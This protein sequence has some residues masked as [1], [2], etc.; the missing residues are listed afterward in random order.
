MK[1]KKRAAILLLAI[2]SLLMV[3]STAAADP[4]TGDEGNT[5][6]LVIIGCA[7][8]MG[9]AGVGSALGLMLAGTAAVAVTGEKP[10]LFGKCV[11]FEV[12]PMTE[13]VY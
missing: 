1:M 6:S 8:A 9:I 10:E 2:I 13:A 7:L 11:V 3:T 5:Q 12:L 4:L